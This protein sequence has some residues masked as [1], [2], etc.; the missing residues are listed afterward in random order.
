MPLEGGM[1]H[2]CEGAIS[3]TG[4]RAACTSRSDCAYEAGSRQPHG[5]GPTSNVIPWGA[6]D[7]SSG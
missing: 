7:G 6:I 4:S 2:S 5:A 1:D 3:M